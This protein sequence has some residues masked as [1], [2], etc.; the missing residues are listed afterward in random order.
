MHHVW[1]IEGEAVGCA[2]ASIMANKPES[3]ESGLFHD[4]KLVFSHCPEGVIHVAIST[5]RLGTVALTTKV[6]GN[7]GLEI[8]QFQVNLVP[9]DVGLWV[10]V[11]QQQTGSRTTMNDVDSAAVTVY[12]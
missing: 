10:A 6:R 3:F 4:S 12:L 8:S 1:I 2:G 9:H 5:V 11:Q 7:D